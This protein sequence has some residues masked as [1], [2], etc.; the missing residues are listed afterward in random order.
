MKEAIQCEIKK[1]EQ[2]HNIRILFAVESGS[3][4]W[5]FPSQDSDYDVRFVYIRR[6]EWYLSIDEKSD[7]I[8][9]PITNLLD[10][11]G[12]DIKKALKLFRKSNPSL[13]EWLSSEIVYHDAYGF[14]DEMIKLR[15]RVFSP[16][17]SIHHYLG[18]AKGNYRD[19]LQGE[20]VKIKKYFY[21]LRPLLACMWIERYNV[22]PP[23]LFQ[24]LVNKL[25]AD[26]EVKS[27]IEKLLASKMAGKEIA[28][29]KRIDVLNDF[30][31]EGFAH[32]TDISPR[33]S[34]EV[35]DPT[36]QL[37]DVYRKYLRLVWD[38]K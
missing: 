15:E 30:I 37:D 21:V 35:N 25:V 24:E 19:Y 34:R 33:Y 6:P 26:L 23:I 12:W 18:M 13:M 8:E 5:G 31:E 1:L 17:I 20:Q 10:I 9:V 22:N 11:N 36:A 27:A 4:A 32:L 29:E 14:K 2:E 7:V 38:F 28:L 16:K 3:R